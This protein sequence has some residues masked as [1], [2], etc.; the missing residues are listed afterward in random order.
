MEILEKLAKSKFRSRFKLRTKELEYIKDKG[1][2]KIRSHACDFIRDRVAPAEPANGA[3]TGGNV[4]LV[5]G[6]KYVFKTDFKVKKFTVSDKKVLKV[7]KS[8]KATI[9][10]SGLVT[11]TATGKKGETKTFENIYVE[12]PV[13]NSKTVISKAS[14]NVSEMLS[15][16][17][18]AKITSYSSSK[19]KVAAI[20]DKGQITILSKGTTK[21]TV[22]IN[23]K[24]YKKSLK[25]KI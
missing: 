15:G 6:G 3:V 10:K 22:I 25:V 12:K 1:L 5:N 21:I 4:L 8:G 9:K 23:G 2:D 17:T 7:S 20:D 24:K 18:H 13:M 11:V 14:F 16:V 19:T